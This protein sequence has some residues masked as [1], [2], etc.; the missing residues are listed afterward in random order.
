MARTSNLILADT[1]RKAVLYASVSSKEQEKEGFSTGAQ[2]NL[3]K[4][5]GPWPVVEPLPH[6][7][8]T[9]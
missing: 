4:R 6:Y 5:A 1:V 8:D 2:L 7:F 3:L 9:E